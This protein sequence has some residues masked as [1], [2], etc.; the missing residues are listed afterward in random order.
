M[1][2]FLGGAA[3]FRYTQGMALLGGKGPS[4]SLRSAQDDGFF[5][6]KSMGNRREQ[7][8]EPFQLAPFLK[9]R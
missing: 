7:K 4:T 8:G 5:I 1:R 3:G 6:P 9:F 2:G